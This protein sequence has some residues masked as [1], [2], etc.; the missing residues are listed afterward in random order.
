MLFSMAGSKETRIFFSGAESFR[1]GKARRLDGNWNWDRGRRLVMTSGVMRANTNTE[2]KQSPE[3]TRLRSDNGTGEVGVA[4]LFGGVATH[5][6]RL[7]ADEL[8]GD[9]VDGRLDVVRSETLGWADDFT[10]VTIS[11]KEGGGGRCLSRGLPR[12]KQDHASPQSSGR[13]RCQSR[14][15]SGL[16]DGEHRS[17]PSI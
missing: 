1:W 12:F 14:G 13:S 17:P 3:P 9:G 4:W 8:G 16:P 10:S 6:T 5:H 2:R 7:P 11:G 15:A